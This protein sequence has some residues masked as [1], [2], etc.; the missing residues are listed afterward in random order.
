M[1]AATLARL[2]RLEA[3]AAKR[4]APPPPTE[5]EAREL[6]ERIV[7]RGLRRIRGAS[8]LSA[9]LEMLAAF[10]AS[11]DEACRMSGG[12]ADALDHIYATVE[13][14]AADEG[15]LREDNCP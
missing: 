7:E 3:A 5:A 14:R 13:R 15:L 2:A 9:R 8:P 10:R 6:T 1:R 12:P 4:R 11:V